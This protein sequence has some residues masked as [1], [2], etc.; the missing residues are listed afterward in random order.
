MPLVTI[1]YGVLLVALGV[2]TYFATG[3]SS[4][5]ALI[6]AFFGA[7]IIVCGILAA[8]GIARMHVMHAAVTI[9]LLGLLGAGG[10]GLPKLPALLSGGDLERPA[11][12]ASQCAM[13]LVSL[14]YMVLAIRSF[15]AAR[16]ARQAN[17]D[18][19]TVAE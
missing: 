7:P 9:A 19:D 18:A 8:K 12:V 14:I 1:L 17:L 13:A 15:I 11:A 6:P 10:M 16:R 3:G 4:V 2:G 5:T